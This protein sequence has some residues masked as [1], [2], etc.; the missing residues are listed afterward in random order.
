MLKGKTQNGEDAVG[1]GFLIAPDLVLTVGHNIFWKSSK[2]D[3]NPKLI[4]N[5]FFYP[6]HSSIEEEY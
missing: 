5:I 1:T 2:H 4:S 3:M 6:G